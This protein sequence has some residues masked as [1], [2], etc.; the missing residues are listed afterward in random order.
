MQAWRIA[1]RSF[2]LDRQG[3]GARLSGGRWNSPGVA[4]I[5]AG[6]SPEI[7]AMEKLV[8]TSD[9]LPQDLVLAVIELPNADGLYR[10][11]TV[12]DLPD[13]WDALPSST[14]AI[15]LGDEFLLA[16]A[17]LGLIVPSA[18]MPEA[19]N[20]VLNP[21]HPEFG[22][23]TISIVRPFEFDSRLRG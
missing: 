11:Y 8:H 7:A 2:A 9:M 15:A 16:T 4:A 6:L 13:G 21:N 22:A 10:R 19:F 23:V 20:V 12:D 3:T 1:K 5:Y 18:V 17:H 14:V